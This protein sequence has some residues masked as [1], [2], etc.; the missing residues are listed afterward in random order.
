MVLVMKFY[1]FLFLFLLTI[2]SACSLPFCH[3]IN[4]AA[5][6]NLYSKELDGERFT[7]FALDLQQNTLYYF[8]VNTYP[9][10]VDFIFKELLKTPI[11]H[12]LYNEYLENYSEI[13][14]S[15]LFCYL[16]HHLR[17]D[18]WTMALLEGD[19]ATK[20]EITKGYNFVYSTFYLGH[21]VQ[22]RPTSTYQEL[23]AKTLDNIPIIT[24]NEL[25]RKSDYQL[26]NGGSTVAILRI[27]TGLST[28][29]EENE[30]VVLPKPLPDITAVAGII[31]EQFSTPLSHLALR[32]R[33][34]HIPHAG[35]KDASVLFTEL[36][37]QYVYFHADT[38]GYELRLAT[39][40]EIKTYCAKHT[41]PTPVVLDPANLTEQ[42]IQPLTA[43]CGEDHTAYGTKAANLAEC[44]KLAL[45]I[46]QGFAIPFYY[47]DNHVKASGAQESINQQKFDE[48]RQKILDHPLDAKL[49]DT[50]YN[51]VKTLPEGGFFVRSSTNAEDLAGFNGAGLYDTYAN[52]KDKNGIAEAIKAVWA[53]IWSPRAYKER[54]RFGIDHNAVYGAILV[55]TAVDATSAGVLVTKDIFDATETMEAY[56]IN[57]S[58]G[59]GQNVVEGDAIPEQIIYNFDNKGIKVLSRASGG[60]I[61]VCDENGGTKLIANPN[62]SDPVLTDEQ[63]TTL[64]L[65][66]HKIVRHYLADYPLDIE[67]LFKDDTLYILQVRP[68]V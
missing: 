19:K 34:W 13:K 36:E 16:V 7:K 53:S 5:S 43:L 24:N 39:D 26:L 67:W 2:S 50:A 27:D 6:F 32:A 40:N 25:Y 14:P 65:A 8:D 15:F 31:T 48:A 29:W 11:T 41:P 57:A 20:E 61:C 51:C 37:G 22:F 38:Q 42:T 54:A 60:M 58:H 28:K 33:G 63:V 18:I 46:P 49:L 44:T 4:S 52:I 45:N 30:L 62:G 35:I 9:M 21:K 55:Q 3:E 10:H 17:Q 68:F 1:R 59:L 56:T 12:A 47:Y 23:I 64:G 66:T